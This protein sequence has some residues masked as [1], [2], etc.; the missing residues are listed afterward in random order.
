MA[1]YYTGHYRTQFTCM[2]TTF[3]SVIGSSADKNGLL[4]YF[5]EG[6]CGSLPCPPYENNKEL[7]CAVCTK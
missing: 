4:F 1:A 7:S 3:K 6:I 5:V 2:D